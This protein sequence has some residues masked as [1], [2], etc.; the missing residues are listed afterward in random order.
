MMSARRIEPTVFQKYELRRSHRGIA[1]ATVLLISVVVLGAVAATASLLTVGTG[2]NLVQDKDTLQALA[3]ADSGISTLPAIT[4]NNRGLNTAQKLTDFINGGSDGKSETLEDNPYPVMTDMGIYRLEATP[5]DTQR[6]TIKA[7]GTLI[8]RRNAEKVILQDFRLGNGEE[9]VNTTT[10]SSGPRGGRFLPPVTSCGRVDVN[11]TV[12]IFTPG[13]DSGRSGR[14]GVEDRGKDNGLA[15]EASIIGIPASVSNPTTEPGLPSI[16]SGSR[17]KVKFKLRTGVKSSEVIKGTI[18][19]GKNQKRAGKPKKPDGLRRGTSN[20]Q[21]NS[22]I[23]Q[24]ETDPRSLFNQ[25][26]DLTKA[27]FK[28]GVQEEKLDKKDITLTNLIGKHY[29]RG[30]PKTLNLCSARDDSGNL[31]PSLVVIDASTA[32]KNGKVKRKPIKFDGKKKQAPVITE[33]STTGGDDDHAPA[34]KV[35]KIENDSAGCAFR[36]VLYIMGD[37]TFTND[38]TFYGAVI[39]EGAPKKKDRYRKTKIQ[40]KFTEQIDKNTGEVK[41][42]MDRLPILAY[43]P[44]AVGSVLSSGDTS[45]NTFSRVT[46][47][48]IWHPIAGTWRQK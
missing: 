35:K 17:V 16:V 27:E 34:K 22:A 43:D 31:I 41:K 7:T 6:V 36:G 18:Q 44:E 10:N 13:G 19:E 15:K 47:G 46:A 20:I 38:V 5:I 9:T 11:E 37:A 29:Y 21:C 23:N 32:D 24:N 45:T 25:Y 28:N 2:R 30:L 48:S 40:G 3:L 14:G 4:E 8:G 26:L 1:L 39:V 12:Q 42:T 33:V